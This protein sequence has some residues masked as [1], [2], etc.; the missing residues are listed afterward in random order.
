MSPASRP[1]LLPS[2]PQAGTML[3]AGAVGVSEVLPTSWDLRSSGKG[4]VTDASERCGK[5][6]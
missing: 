5:C 3:R 4:L 2:A 1:W 6:F